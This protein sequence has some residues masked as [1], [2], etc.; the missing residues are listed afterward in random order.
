VKAV[1]SGKVQV[2][3]VYP[4]IT[5]RAV[6]VDIPLPSV[7][8]LTDYVAQPHQAPAFTRRNVFLRD[9][10]RCQYCAK[11]YKTSDLSLDHVYPRCMGGKLEWENTVTC[12]KKCNGKKGSL[13]PADLRSVGM[14][15]LREPRT[16]SKYDLANV[17]GRMIPRRIHPTWAPYMGIDLKGSTVGNNQSN[18]PLESCF[19]NSSDIF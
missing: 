1:F 6:N 12:C 8:A 13:L 16:P 19:E 2:V 17:A 15:L 14:R 18:S 9:A 11:Y 3:D 7:I 5:V 4:S 10:Y